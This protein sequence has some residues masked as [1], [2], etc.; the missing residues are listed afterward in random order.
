MR[1]RCV[2]HVHALKVTKSG[3]GIY[4]S[5]SV[6]VQEEVQ[7]FKRRTLKERV[8]NWMRTDT[9]K[10]QTASSAGLA[11]GRERRAVGWCGAVM[12]RR[13]AVRITA[14]AAMVRTVIGSPTKSQPRNRATTGF[15]KA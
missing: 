5:K 15:T 1:L 9:T 4:P 11:A 7:E 14:A 12:T 2:S 10:R 3:K 8:G 6:K 13:T